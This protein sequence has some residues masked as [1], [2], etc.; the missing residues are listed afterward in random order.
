MTNAVISFTARSPTSVLSPTADRL[1]RTVSRI[2]YSI[3]AK[4]KKTV[5][6]PFGNKGAVGP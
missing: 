4:G 2:I 1:V 5:S 6:A 3:L